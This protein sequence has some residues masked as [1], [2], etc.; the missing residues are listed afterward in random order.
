M[1][2]REKGRER[3]SNGEKNEYETLLFRSISWVVGCDGPSL[4]SD[5]Q[6]FD[7]N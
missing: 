1:C 4:S 7:K 5:L 6:I 2:E 3:E